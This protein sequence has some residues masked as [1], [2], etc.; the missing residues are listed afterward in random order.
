MVETQERVGTRV[1]VG[2]KARVRV[3]ASARVRGWSQYWGESEADD[4]AR[5]ID[6]GVG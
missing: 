4:Y 5:A 1:G 2:A 6:D 3:G